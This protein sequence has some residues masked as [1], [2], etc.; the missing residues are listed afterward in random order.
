MLAELFVQRVES[1]G[2]GGVT[3]SYTLV[4]I[5]GGGRRRKLADDLALDDARF[6]ERHLECQLGI[7]DRRVDGE[8]AR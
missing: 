6:L 5:D 8:A 3:V 7:R 2:R 4:A 1:G